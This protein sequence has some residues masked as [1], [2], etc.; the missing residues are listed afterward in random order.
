MVEDVVAKAEE[1]LAEGAKISEVSEKLN[2]KKNKLQKAV[3][4]GRVREPVKKA[5]RCTITANGLGEDVKA[6]RVAE[7]ERRVA[8][9]TN[10]CGVGELDCIAPA[11]STQ[12]V[13]ASW[14]WRASCWW[15][16]GNMS[17]LAIEGAEMK[18]A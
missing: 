14:R 15:R 8:S 18:A 11:Q 1:L 9:A 17:P 4:A 13:E 12:T 16:C 7:T 3:R 5:I 10:P 2:V 6:D